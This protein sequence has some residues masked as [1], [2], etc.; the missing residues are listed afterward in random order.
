MTEVLKSYY[1]EHKTV[2]EENFRQV[3]ESFDV[4]AIHKMRTSTKRL[5]ALFQLLEFLSEE[6]FKAKK[7]LSRLRLYFKHGGKIRE[8]QI[9]E[10]LVLQ[11]EHSLGKTF[12]EYLG[13]LK[14]RKHKEIARFLKSRPDLGESDT[15]LNDRKVYQTISDL[16]AGDRLKVL[17]SAFIDDRVKRIHN[18][19]NAPASNHR[20]HQNRTFLKQIYYLHKI[21]LTLSGKKIILFSDPERIRE[22][23]QYL[24]TWHDLVNSPVFLNAFFRTGEGISGGRYK[25]LKERIAA[26]RKAM[27][28]HILDK[29]YPELSGGEKPV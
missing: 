13:Y 26:D 1:G 22:I 12:P 17:T 14:G 11:Y 6:K 21:L 16:L 20:I 10:M 2:F 29:F 23:E 5:R 9:E 7:Q 25:I 18:N 15:I 19:I 4:E 24:G 27:R 8:I 28:N 3:L